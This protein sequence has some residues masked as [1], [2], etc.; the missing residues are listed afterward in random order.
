MVLTV[1]QIKYIV[2]AIDTSVLTL[3]NHNTETKLNR[4]WFI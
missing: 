4:K 3:D 1:K 2:F